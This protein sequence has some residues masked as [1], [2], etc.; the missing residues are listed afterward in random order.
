V[1]PTSICSLVPR[2]RALVRGQV[3]SVSTH[4]WPAV[5][6]MV[7]LGDGTGTVTLRFLGRRDLPGFESGRWLSA[8][9]TPAQAPGRLVILNPRYKFE[10]GP[11]C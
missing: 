2:R 6:F 8:E 9:G 1:S 5:S 3:V 10:P 4:E 7:R 11:E